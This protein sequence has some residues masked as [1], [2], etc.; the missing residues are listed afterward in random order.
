MNSTTS[1]LWMLGCAAA[2]FICTAFVA[3]T[4]T[5]AQPVPCC[6]VSF[7]NNTACAITFYIRTA[8]G[9][10]GV[11]VPAGGNVVI[12]LPPSL[13]DDPSIYVVDQC[14]NRV[15]IPFGCVNVAL[16]PDCCTQICMTAGI[17]GCWFVSADPL[18]FDCFCILGP[19]DNQLSYLEQ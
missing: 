16:P 6:D 8:S 7:D 9:P 5:K 3:P 15:K 18:P 13:C 17:A 4:A 11:N 2:L 12:T 1:R 14:N 19:L 10:I